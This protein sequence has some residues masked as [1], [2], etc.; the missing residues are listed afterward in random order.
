MKC[1]QE[2]LKE[3]KNMLHDK[4]FKSR[5]R[6]IRICI[7]LME[8][9]GFYFVDYEPSYLIV[10]PVQFDFEKRTKNSY[11]FM[12]FS[13][14][15]SIIKIFRSIKMQLVLSSSVGFGTETLSANNINLAINTLYENKGGKMSTHSCAKILRDIKKEEF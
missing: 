8:E 15:I 1:N 5:W 6:R 2:F 12:T 10:Y 4:R 11:F 9:L 13:H 3:L 14:A 7:V